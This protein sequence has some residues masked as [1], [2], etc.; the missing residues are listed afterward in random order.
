M[1]LAKPGF[2]F[3]IIKQM[4]LLGMRLGILPKMLKGM[5]VQFSE[6]S[7]N[8]STEIINDNPEE[9][10]A[11]LKDY[12]KDKWNIHSIGS[13]KSHRTWCSEI[14]TYYTGTPL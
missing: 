9:I 12:A 14:I 10:W 1:A 5:K 11:D 3:G 4:R 8:D 7:Q 2:E 13:P 6:L